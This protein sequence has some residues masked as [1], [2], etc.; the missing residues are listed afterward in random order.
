MPKPDELLLVCFVKL[1]STQLKGRGLPE[2][3]ELTELVDRVDEAIFGAAPG[4]LDPSA[5][6]LVEARHGEK[7]MR[8]VDNLALP[9]HEYVVNVLGEKCDDGA[10][11][12]HSNTN[13]VPFP[14][15]RK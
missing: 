1:D 4:S 6:Y 13:V 15:Q 10:C 12:E 8:T 5:L 7:L 2:R 11:A 14:L 9:F 3:R